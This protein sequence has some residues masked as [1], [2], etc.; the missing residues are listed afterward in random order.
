M[1]LLDGGTKA[2]FGE[3]LGGL[4]LPGSV[5]TQESTYDDKGDLTREATAHPC[6]VQVDQATERMVATEGYTIDDRAIFVLADSYDGELDTDCLVQVNAGPYAGTV[7]KVGAPIDRDPA[8][9]YWRCRGTPHGG[10]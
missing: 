4:F 9:A 6:R 7:W 10:A 3:V 1:G 5:Q 2:L 8:G